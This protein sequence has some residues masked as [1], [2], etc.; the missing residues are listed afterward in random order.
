MLRAPSPGGALKPVEHLSNFSVFQNDKYINTAAK[1]HSAPNNH[2]KQ[3]PGTILYS[4]LKHLGKRRGIR[5]PPI[6]QRIER[7]NFH[8]WNLEQPSTE[9][10]GIEPTYHEPFQ[11]VVPSPLRVP[12]NTRY[13]FKQ[14]SMLN[15]VGIN[16]SYCYV[17]V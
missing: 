14:L 8:F 1:D 12:L 15:F 5:A 7:C 11:K 9:K 16:C 17:H 2:I 13:T 10:A 6:K 4:M 3:L